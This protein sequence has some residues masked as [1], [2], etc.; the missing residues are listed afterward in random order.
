MRRDHGVALLVVLMLLAGLLIVGQMAMLLMDNVTQ[1]SGAFRRSEQSSYCAEE[2]L[3]LGRAWAMQNAAKS[4][5]INSLLLSGAPGHLGQGLLTDPA[6]PT[7]FS[8]ANVTVKDLCLIPALPAAATTYGGVAFYG[9]GGICR[10]IP[11]GSPNAN[12]CGLGAG[13]CSMYRVNLVD[14][15]DEIP[16]NLIDP[17]TDENQAF[18]I[19]SECMSENVNPQMGSFGGT[20]YESNSAAQTLDQV[21]FVMVNEAGG[22]ACPGGNRG[23]NA[24]CGGGPPN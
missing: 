17:Y 23:N 24:G 15:M 14:D 5:S 12:W 22:S 11:A 16:P 4:G 9:L 8:A 19:R 21:A 3:N 18:F 2:G 1:R 20:S 13:K 10:L 7:D 6:N